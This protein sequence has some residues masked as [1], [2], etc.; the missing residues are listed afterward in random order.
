[1]F[2]NLRETILALNA[3]ANAVVSCERA[4]KLKK[5]LFG[6]GLA[7]T[8]LGFG[9][10]ILCFVLFTVAG[11][12]SFAEEWLSARIL[13]PFFLFLP[14]FFVGSVGTALL[15]LSARIVI[16]EYTTGLV[17]ETIGF[18]CPKCKDVIT[19]EEIY[20]SKCG[21]KLRREC[22]VCKYVNPMNHNYCEK[23]GNRL[24]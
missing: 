1:M 5:R 3:D 12:S 15:S 17:D 22:P 14:S 2:R 7:L 19:P 18:H 6:I 21:T 23:C 8:V 11:F 4:K 16:A 13:V 9:G 20:C 10:G 24:E